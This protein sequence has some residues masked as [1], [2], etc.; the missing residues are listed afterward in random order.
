MRALVLLCCLAFVPAV[1]LAKAETG[2]AAPAFALV[3][4]DGKT[5]KLSDLKGKIVVVDFWASWCGP[6][7]KGLPAMDALAAAYA[8]KGKPVVF[9][10]INIDSKRAAADKILSD[11][12]ITSLTIL[13]DPS[14]KVV[15][16]YE[17]PTMPT[18]YVIDKTGQ[19]RF[20]NQGFEPGDEKKIAAQIDSL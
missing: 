20:V 15:E 13:F 16:Q 19:V 8:A 2:K 7:K 18:S 12:K 1:A 10:A 14:S 11:K 4:R 3:G 17:V 5:V 6:C 9:V